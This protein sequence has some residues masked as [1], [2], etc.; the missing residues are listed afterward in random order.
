[1]ES[2]SRI[3]IARSPFTRGLLLL[4]LLLALLAGCGSGNNNNNNGDTDPVDPV[5]PPPVVDPEFPDYTVVELAPGDDL[6][7]RALE[8]LITADPKTI[9]Q[10]PAGVYDF[11]S[12]LSSSVDNIVIRGTGT[13]EEEG[14]VLRF[15]N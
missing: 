11:T 15:D 8:A 4:P 2:P 10:F 7:T 6:E 9:I 13:D 5:D 14:T 12:E 3:Q 1:M